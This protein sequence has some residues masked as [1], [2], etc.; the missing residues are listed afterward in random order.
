MFIIILII[1]I[2]LYL[3]Y[4]NKCE[5]FNVIEYD[6]DIIINEEIKKSEFLYFTNDDIKNLFLEIFSSENNYQ[7]GLI[8][9]NSKEIF[10]RVF[11]LSKD[12]I[13]NNRKVINDIL[14]KE[15]ID[16]EV[17]SLNQFISVLL[18]INGIK[19]YIDIL[20]SRTDK[21]IDMQSRRNIILKNDDFIN[22]FKHIFDKIPI[23]EFNE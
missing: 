21:L 9:F 13:F 5:S 20:L 8:I 18:K 1:L 10:K 14:N 22:F 17:V 23:P 12:D 11:I 3:S 16:Y 4:Q 2:I 6:L 7:V 15:F 19:E